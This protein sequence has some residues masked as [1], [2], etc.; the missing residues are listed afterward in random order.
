MRTAML[1]GGLLC[2]TAAPAHATFSIVAYDSTTQ[3]LGVA[4]QSRAFNVGAGVAWARAGAGAVATQSFTNESFGP[5]G[6]ELLRR[7]VRPNAALDSLLADDTGREQRQV[8]LVDARGEA[9]PFTG[10]E[11]MEWAGGVARPGL[12]VQGNILAS[13]E[14]VRAMVA[15]FDRASGELS[16]RLLAAL[17]AAQAAGGD[18]RGQQSAALLVVRPSADYPEYEERYVSLRVDDHA[19]PIREL[20]RLFRLHEASDLAEAHLRY[21]RLFEA[22]GDRAG[23]KREMDRVGETLR[24][25][26]EDPEASAGALNALAWY[27]ATADA[28]LPE[29][30]AAAHRAAALDPE[31]TEILD[32]LA[33]CQFRTGDVAGALATIQKALD[34]N[35][36]DAYLKS[37]KKRFEAAWTER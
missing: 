21:A 37:Q 24:R 16:V 28:F 7:G 26:L 36:D 33:E 4:V 25:L 15:A 1:A 17:E 6:L 30:L 22:R 32:T 34:A 9:A 3:E 12:A 13:E 29:A 20:E 2:F 23:A 8:G 5:R 18:K 14:V 27:T 35:P 10:S 19:E 11:C 31:N